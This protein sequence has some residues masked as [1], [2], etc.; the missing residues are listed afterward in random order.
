MQDPQERVRANGYA[1]LSG[2]SSA[3]LASR[4]QR[5]R[6]QQI[7][8]AVG[9]TRIAS[10]CAIEALGKDLA[11]ASRHVA[12]PA[13]AV[14][15]QLDHLAAPRL[16]ERATLVASVQPSAQLTA[17]GTRNAHA[18]WFGN[19]NQTSVAL[20]DDQDDAPAVRH[21]PKR[22]GHRRSLWPRSRFRGD[23]GRVLSRRAVWTRSK[24]ISASVLRPI[25][26]NPPRRWHLAT[27]RALG[28]G[29][30]RASIDAATG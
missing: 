3:T 26:G 15:A 13:T 21:C 5:E 8:G 7:G 29:S 6:R 1:S 10:Q 17:L 2:Q 24:L 9:P 18:R 4:L 12:E 28:S 25:Y 22:L 30:H 14:D 20:D 11:R 27:A 16:I 23:S 19:K